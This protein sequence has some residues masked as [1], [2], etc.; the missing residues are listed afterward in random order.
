M[1]IDTT[2]PLKKCPVCG[3]RLYIDVLYQYSKMYPINKKTGAVSYKSWIKGTDGP[4]DCSALICENNDF[5][6]NYDYEI[7]IPTDLAGEYYIESV[8]DNYY[9][10]ER[11]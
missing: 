4:L 11:Y 3:G 2:K 7:E 8:D 1:K 10:Q 6:T 9:L 5:R